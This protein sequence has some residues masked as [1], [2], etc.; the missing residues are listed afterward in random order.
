MLKDLH[1]EE[2]YQELSSII[3]GLVLTVRW[4]SLPSTER[5]VSF[6]VRIHITEICK[7]MIRSKGYSL[8]TKQERE[9][10]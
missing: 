6:P 3:K 9:M 7:T 10:Q 2:F 8:I 5:N 4:S 1:K